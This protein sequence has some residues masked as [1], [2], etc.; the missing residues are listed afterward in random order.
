VG[1]YYQKTQLSTDFTAPPSPI[2]PE[3]H[4]NAYYYN[5]KTYFVWQEYVSGSNSVKYYIRAWYHSTQ[6]W[7]TK[8]EIA[9]I[10][11]IRD[12]HTA[13]AIGILPNKKLWVTYGGHEW[14]TGIPQYYKV[15]ATAEDESSF[16]GQTQYS[17]TKINMG[18]TYPNLCCFSDKMVIFMRDSVD[19]TTTRWMRNTTTNGTTW[20]GWT[21]IVHHGSNYAPYMIFRREYSFSGLILM[22]GTRVDYA[23]EPDVRE[24][25]YFAYSDDQG[26]TWRKADGTV[27]SLPLTGSNTLIWTESNL[28]Q[29]WAMLD[30]DDRPFVAAWVTPTIKSK[31]ADI[32]GQLVTLENGLK[33]TCKTRMAATMS[34]QH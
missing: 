14:S 17:F 29:A 19:A 4:P 31:S 22:A 7:G 15:S 13:P 5:G 1:H 8:Y 11:N 2:T 6:S 9:D 3:N 20:S 25:I 30:A 28:H 21:E 33:A 16:A 10:G 26:V 18:W 32:M 27:L 24:N 23:P 34:S 12:S